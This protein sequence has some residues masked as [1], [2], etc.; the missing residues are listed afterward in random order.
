MQAVFDDAISSIYELE[1]K[2]ERNYVKLVTTNTI[3]DDYL[4]I[5]L[6]K[7]STV[8]LIQVLTECLFEM[9]QCGES[10]DGEVVSITPY[11]VMDDSN[12]TVC[13]ISCG[14]ED[15]DWYE[16]EWD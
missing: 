14:E 4:T 2:G 16:D 3:E 15:D 5:R 10:S 7:K 1:V 9:D 13:F 12:D 11:L 6:N 8:G